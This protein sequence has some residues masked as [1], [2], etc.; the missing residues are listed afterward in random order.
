MTQPDSN[1]I[2]ATASSLEILEYL[3][4]ADGAVGVTRIADDLTISKSMVYNHLAT[5]RELGYVAKRDRK[6][7]PSLHL[8][9][10]SE[11]IRDGLDVYREGY[12][13]VANLAEATG[14]TIELF[15]MEEHYGMP[16]C[17]VSG[18][19]NWSTPHCI[20][21]RMPLYVNSPG[22]AILASLPP[23]TVDDV[24]ASYL[25]SPNDEYPF[26]RASIERD[27]KKV[28]DSGVS[29]SRGEHHSDV[30]AISSPIE[31]PASA[32]D[33][34]LAIVGPVDELEGRYLEE[35]LVGH[36]V[37]CSQTISVALTE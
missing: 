22:K 23:E 5:L 10:V 7:V 9:S 14:E 33:A 26:D 37:S 11:R 4:D 31:T 12:D 20:G 2:N 13:E 21:Q 27:I 18:S 36:V 29:F 24:L 17:I 19:R 8:L 1:T 30:I 34:S 15:I 32:H 16:L 35:D 3:A 28:R 6:Y 25:N